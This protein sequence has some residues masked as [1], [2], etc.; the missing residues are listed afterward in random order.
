MKMRKILLLS[1]VALLLLSCR[2]QKTTFVN[3]N[4]AQSETL[5]RLQPAKI[6]TS[7][8]FDFLSYENG[9]YQMILYSYIIWKNH[10]RQHCQI[11]LYPKK[12]YIIEEDSLIGEGW[13]TASM[14]KQYRNYQPSFKCFSERF[15]DLS[16][17][18]KIQVLDGMSDKI[19]ERQVSDFK[20]IPADLLNGLN[21]MGKDTSS[22]LNKYE[23]KYLNFIFGLESSNLDFGKAKVGF[24][25]SKEDFF[26]QERELFSNGAESGVGG[27]VLY[28]FS[29][30][31]KDACGDYDAAITY[32]H[33]AIIP[34]G[35]V[36][37]WLRKKPTAN[38]H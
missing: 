35:T 24:L 12:H 19:Q 16:N 15:L 13:M 29:A 3:H 18:E 9:Q 2:T 4:V 20:K 21:N 32:W 10:D 23:A 1:V 28:I 36:V 37:K 7:A 30:T 6:I 17:D 5:I 26:K 38:S 25:G 31:Q 34:A 11:S 27:C 8:G 22:T 14:F 33:K